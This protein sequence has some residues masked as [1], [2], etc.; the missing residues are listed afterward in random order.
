MDLATGRRELHRFPKGE[1]CDECKARRW[2]TDSSLRYCENG[3]LI[4]SYIPFAQEDEYGEGQGRIARRKKEVRKKEAQQLT[5]V[6]ARELF[7]ECLQLLIRKQVLWLQ[8]QGDQGPTDTPS[9]LAALESVVRDLWDL[10]VRYFHGLTLTALAK[11]DP[12]RSKSHSHSRSRSQSRATPGSDGR[13]LYSS[14]ATDTENYTSAGGGYTTGGEYTTGGSQM[15]RKSRLRS[16]RLWQSGPDEKWNVP[17]VIETL[18]ICY[19][20]GVLLQLPYRIGDFYQW[21]KNDQIPFLEATKHVPKVMRER[22]PP[23]YY[24]ALSARQI[25]LGGGKL[26]ASVRALIQGYILNNEMQFPGLNA[27]PILWRWTRDLG[28]PVDVYAGVLELSRLSNEEYCFPT[29]LTR[30]YRLDYPDILLLANTIMVTKLLHPFKRMDAR[31]VPASGETDS[32]DDEEKDDDDDDDEGA[33]DEPALVMDWK[34]WQAVFAEADKK[35][36]SFASTHPPLSRKDMGRLQET[37]AAWLSTR[38]ID[39]YMDWYQEHRLTEKEGESCTCATGIP[40]CERSVLTGVDFDRP[41]PSRT[42]VS[43]E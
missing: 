3:H 25:S 23:S 21:A 32:E 19:L 8:K 27:P 40:F 13:T 28:L 17:P 26:H 12:R 20:G 36:P 4:E 18:A 1:T 39:D 29:D 14:Q 22:L 35:F 30:L 31:Q 33:L 37:D 41:S 16:A 11:N 43:A 38:Q 9:A 15:S 6:E 24:R 34:K 10:R 7:L 5:G 2:Y 42:A